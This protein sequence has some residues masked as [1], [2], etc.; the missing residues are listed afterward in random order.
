MNDQHLLL[1]KI[2]VIHAIKCNSTENFKAAIS[3]FDKLNEL[4]SQILNSDGITFEKISKEIETW[5]ETKPIASNSEISIL[6]SRN[7]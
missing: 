2:S 6:M 3:S 7:H 1:R 5:A 4:K